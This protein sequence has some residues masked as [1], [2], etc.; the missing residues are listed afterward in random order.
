VARLPKPVFVAVVTVVWIGSLYLV[1]PVSDNGDVQGALI[2]GLTLIAGIVAGTWWIL[3]APF[4]GVVTLLA[5][6]AL[7][8]CEDCRDELGVVGTAFLLTLFAALAAVALAA[9][10]GLRKGIRW[11]WARRAA[12]EH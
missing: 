9:G 8:P 7:S 10:V 3:L 4:A 12:A 5:V 2:F 1:E 6:D 11:A